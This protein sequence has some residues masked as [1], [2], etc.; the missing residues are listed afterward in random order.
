MTFGLCP[1]HFCSHAAE[2]AGYELLPIVTRKV[3]ETPK[4]IGI[5]QMKKESIICQAEHELCTTP[6]SPE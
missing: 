4:P 1:F 6:N 2:A 3:P 5:Q